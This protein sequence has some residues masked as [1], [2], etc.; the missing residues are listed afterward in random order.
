MDEMK[1]PI[2]LDF[3]AT[4]APAEDAPVGQKALDS[5]RPPVRVVL[6]ALDQGKFDSQRSLDELAALAEAN[7]MQAVATVCQKRST[8]EAAT[9][10]GEG[11]VEEARLVCLNT[12]AEAA[13]FDGELTGSQIRNLSAALQVE[14]LDRTMLILEIF[15]ARAT[16][17]EGKLQTELATLK[18]RM[19][20]LQG[21]GEALSR[22]GGGGGGGGGA[23][24]G[25]GETKLE[26][27][28]RY[29]RSRIEKLE[30][31]LK[32]LEKRR[33]E[34]RRARQKNG[35]PVISLVGYT[36]VGKSSLTNALCGAEIFE[37]DMLFATLDP[38]ARK[39]TL[40]SGLQVILVDT[41]GF[42]SRLPHDLV[43]AFKSTLEEAACSDIILKIA[44]AS[45]SEAAE[46]L[47][48][49]D[50]VLNDLGCGDIPQVTVYNKCDR[51][52]VAPYDPDVLL[53]SAK[54]GY[55]LDSLL[56]K[57]DEILAHRVR[58]IEVLLPYDK[59]AL[60]DVF[61]TRGS[62]LAEEYR[63]NGVYYKATVKVDDLGCGDI[64][65]VTVY[66]KCD[67]TGV[68]PYDPDVLLVSA[69]T[70][71]GLDSLLAKIDEIL[72]HRVRTIEVLLPYDKLA[73]ADVFRTRGSVL[74]EEY[75]ENGVY[76]K[77]TVKVDDLHR[78]EAYLL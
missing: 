32:E 65:Q 75:R 61:R 25:A 30:S 53:V 34:T 42:V 46:Q 52:G 41:V 24:R 26:L 14:V 3:T 19:P 23:R 49:T 21:L 12:D 68:A 62:V 15:R 58:T 48:V 8:P 18:Y 59:L 4:Q 31:R 45:D 29:L 27:D 2:T 38:T 22:Q 11:K 50:E 10:L 74:A 47:S 57:I 76:Y 60:A 13:I 20:R 17:N 66:N 55:G 37:A 70:G 28:R 54:T 16:T 9:L 5:E 56:A 67:R 73:L 43:D 35:V 33:G 78:F 71:Y 39:C 40:P 7:G 64:P 6:L 69:K 72:A 51:T 63:E 77:A 44:D 1:D 36:N